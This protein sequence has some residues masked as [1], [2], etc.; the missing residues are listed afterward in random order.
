MPERGEVVDG[1][2]EVNQDDLPYHRSSWHGGPDM[3][4]G[5]PG[6]PNQ[7]LHRRHLQRFEAHFDQARLWDVEE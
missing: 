4:P 7:I 5:V 1:G 2:D 3:P 6:P